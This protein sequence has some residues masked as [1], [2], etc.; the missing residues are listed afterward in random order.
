MAEYKGIMTY[1]EI[2]EGKLPSIS[3]EVLGCGRRLADDLGQELC[4]VLVG[5]DVGSLAQE[6]I[7]F[8]TDKVYV[9]DNPLLKEYQTDSYLSVVG[10]IVCL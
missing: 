5:S 7:T 1:C 2:T 9:V 4:T 10:H 3:Y 6:V 8:G